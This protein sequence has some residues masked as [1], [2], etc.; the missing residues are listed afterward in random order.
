MPPRVA[1]LLTLMRRDSIAVAAGSL[2]R[3]S[4]VTQETGIT[5]EIFTTPGNGT[6]FSPHL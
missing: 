4:A 3:A 5:A 2:M 1:T 6:P